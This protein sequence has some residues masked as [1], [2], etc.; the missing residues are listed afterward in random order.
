MAT[1]EIVNGILAISGEASFAKVYDNLPH[2][3][4][5]LLADLEEA[6]INILNGMA[7]IVMEGALEAVAIDVRNYPNR[8]VEEPEMEKVI[9][10]A[11]D[12]FNENFH[13]NI[14]LLRRRI[15]DS[16]L[17][18]KLY[19]IGEESPTYVCLSYLRESEERLL[20]KIRARL[21]AV[22]PNI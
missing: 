3:N 19:L 7:V 15:K 12:G 13:L 14:Q 8:S 21:E 6:I 18:N 4:L 20:E 22:R 9:R 10:G 16:R 11:H 1:I 5:A 2:P 17:R